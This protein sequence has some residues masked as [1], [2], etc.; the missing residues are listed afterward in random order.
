[1]SVDGIACAGVLPVDCKLLSRRAEVSTNIYTLAFHEE[2]VVSAVICEDFYHRF[3]EQFSDLASKTAPQ[4][5]IKIA[6]KS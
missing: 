1:M 3:H 2:A 4:S 6:C 5:P